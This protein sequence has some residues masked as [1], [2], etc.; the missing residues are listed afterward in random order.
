M[1]AIGTIRRFKWRLIAI[2]AVAML[3]LFVGLLS[4]QHQPLAGPMFGVV[5]GAGFVATLTW[6]P[7]GYLAWFG[8]SNFP[9]LTAF[10][11]IFFWLV[12]VLWLYFWIRLLIHVVG[13]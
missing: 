11:R 9:S 6:F 13:H 1:D 7:L 8:H 10:H 5:Y 2:Q 12:A 4:T 3:V